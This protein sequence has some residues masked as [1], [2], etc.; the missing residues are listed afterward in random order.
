MEEI[1][2][3]S[4]WMLWKE[5]NH[6]QKKQIKE[7]FPCLYDDEIKGMEWILRRRGWDGRVMEGRNSS[8]EKPEDIYQEE[9]SVEEDSTIPG[10]TEGSLSPD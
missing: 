8:R 6:Y 9:N 7:R 10:S 1:K 4:G 5:L 2:K 3:T